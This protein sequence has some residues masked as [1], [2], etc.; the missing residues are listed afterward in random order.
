L[1]GANLEGAILCGANL[2]GAKLWGAK[3]KGAVVDENV[4]EEG[5]V[6]EAALEEADVR[7]S[8]R[9]DDA[10]ESEIVVPVELKKQN[11][12]DASNGRSGK[13][14]PFTTDQPLPAPAEKALS[15]QTEDAPDEIA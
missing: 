1:D 11:L 7:K 2:K 6:D 15:R 12:E 14:L 4:L 9:K 3:L 5:L 13:V 10:P 8:P